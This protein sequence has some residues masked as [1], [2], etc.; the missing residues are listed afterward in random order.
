VQLH[1]PEK[2]EAQCKEAIRQWMKTGVLRSETYTNPVRR[3]EEQGLFVDPG[4][5]VDAT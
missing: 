3:N 1:C 5:R 4:K 2:H